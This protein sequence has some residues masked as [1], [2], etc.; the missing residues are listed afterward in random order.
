MMVDDGSLSVVG[1]VGG[2]PSAIGTADETFLAVGAT[3]GTFSEVGT[4]DRISAVGTDGSDS[5]VG[6]P[7]GTRS[8]FGTGDGI[9]SEVGICDG[10]LAVGTVVDTWQHISREQ[11]VGKS[12]CHME[13]KTNKLGREVKTS[14]SRGL[15]RPTGKERHRTP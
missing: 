13:G 8:A 9:S 7:N 10:T 1:T 5:A 15:E 2:S 11:D 6:T 14:T 3:D 4:V 12:G